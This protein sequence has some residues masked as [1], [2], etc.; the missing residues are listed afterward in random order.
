MESALSL[1]SLIT[2]IDAWLPQTQCRQCGYDGCLPYAEAVAQGEADINECPP[3]G[4]VTI[5]ALADL[6]GRPPRP[7]D[8]RRAPAKPRMLAQIEEA[9]CIGCTLCLKA[10]PVDA[11]VGATKRMHTVIAIECTGCELCL[12]PCPTDCIRLLPAPADATGPWPDRSLKEAQRARARAT[13]RHHRLA[14]SLV[15]E[16]RQHA[17]ADVERVRRQAEIR[18]AVMRAKAKRRRLLEE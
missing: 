3:G 18:A 12:P 10:C 15:P 9:G 4:D 17:P 6:L 2:G 1:A 5:Q 16:R 8:P 11:I 7:L 13:A 14:A